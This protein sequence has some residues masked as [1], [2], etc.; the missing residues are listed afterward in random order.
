MHEVG[1]IRTASF[2]LG[3]MNIVYNPD[4]I[5]MTA[6]VFAL[7]LLLFIWLSR[8]IKKVP[9]RKQMFLETVMSAFDK[10]VKDTIGTDY[11]KYFPLITTLFLFVMF[12]NW[13]GVVPTLEEP[14]KDLNTPLGLAMVIFFVTHFS[15]VKYKGLIGYI[16][17]FFEPIPFLF[18]LNIVGEIGKFVSLFF[19][20]FG[21]IF[22]GSVII[23]VAYTMILKTA[24]TAWIMIFL[25][26]V[27]YGY[28]GIFVGMIQ[29]FVFTMLSMTYIAVAKN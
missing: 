6:I 16:K 9:G 27:L 7:I 8:G 12:S 24:W 4:T 23:W 26:P 15:G 3:G 18:P 14:T 10:L 21:N 19:R 29:A 28:F 11:R 20:L 1:T 5:I 22:G 13:L 17:E 25:G 2:R